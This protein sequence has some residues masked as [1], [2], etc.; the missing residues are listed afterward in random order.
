MS[1]E[2]VLATRGLNASKN[3]RVSACV[4]NIF[5]FP[6]ITGL[7]KNSPMAASAACKRFE[8]LSFLGEGLNAG[9]YF[10]C[11]KLQR[12]ASASGNMRD[13]RR[14]T[15]LLDRCYGISTADDGYCSGGRGGCHGARNRQSSLRERRLFKHS[16]RAV[17]K[18]RACPGNF[19]LK[20]AARCWAHV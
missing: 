15:R 7:R 12:G 10:A 5:Q 1:Q 3:A 2:C 17:P 19:L 4:L 20:K 8:C 16:H 11:Q 14:D 6:A 13:L 9:Q 18:Y